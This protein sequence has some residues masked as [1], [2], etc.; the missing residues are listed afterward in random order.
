MRANPI[1]AHSQLSS[2]RQSRDVTTYFH[3][4]FLNTLNSYFLIICLIS[5][6]ILIFTLYIY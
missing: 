6:S 4:L 5:L 1:T 2:L 3:T